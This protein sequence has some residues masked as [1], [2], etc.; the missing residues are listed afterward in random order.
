[1]KARLTP[2]RALLLVLL[3]ALVVGVAW[4]LRDF[5]RDSIVQ[6]LV[7]FVWA[8]WILLQSVPQ[9]VYWGLF[10]L[11]AL[12][13]A[14]RSLMA[15]RAQASRFERPPTPRHATLTRLRYWQRGLE[16]MNGNTFSRER[17]MHD[18]Q[19]LVLQVLAEHDRIGLD[20]MRARLLNGELDLSRE[21]PAIQALLDP[22]QRRSLLMDPVAQPRG[23]RAWLARLLGRAPK[24][25][26]EPTVDVPA[27]VTW[28]EKETGKVTTQ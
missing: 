11:A 4:A 6:P 3:L 14:G 20:E 5:V 1:M 12:I 22:S 19:Y 9:F 18:L 17:I 13:V 28:L 7:V 8:I 25:A 10:L 2:R 16:S 23:L 27:I 24:P 15:R 21:Q 26:Q